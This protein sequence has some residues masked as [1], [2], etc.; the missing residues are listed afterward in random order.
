M[1]GARWADDYFWVMRSAFIINSACRQFFSQEVGFHS[2]YLRYASS[3]KLPDLSIPVSEI[4]FEGNIPTDKIHRS[5]VLASGPGGQFVNKTPTKCWIRFNVKEADWIPKRLKE[6]FMKKYGNQI[7]DAGEWSTYSMTTRAQDQNLENCLNTLPKKTSEYLKKELRRLMNVGSYIKSAFK[8][9]DRPNGFR[10]RISK[11]GKRKIERK[12]Q[13]K[14]FAK[15]KAVNNA[16][17]DLFLLC[18]R[19]GIWIH[20]ALDGTNR[21]FLS[22]VERCYGVRDCIWLCQTEVLGA[23]INGV[24]LLALCFTIFIE[25]ITRLFEPEPIK[26]P[27]NV[28]I[29]GVIGFIINLIGMIMFHAH[30]HG[31]THRVVENM[32]ARDTIEQ[33]EGRHLIGSHQDRAMCTLWLKILVGGDQLN[34][35]GVFLHVVSDA[36]GSVIVIATALVSW[37]VP[38]YE[39]LKLYM[40]PVLSI[41][42]VLLMICTTFP[43]V[44]ETALI[45]LQTTPKYVSIDGIVAIHEFHVWRLVG[46]RIIATIHIRFRSLK[47]YLLAAEQIRSIFHDN[48]IHSAT[49][50]PEFSEMEPSSG[51]VTECNFACLPT[52]CPLSESGV[53]C[54]AKTAVQKKSGPTT[55]VLDET[56]STG[57]EGGNND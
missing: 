30:S 36:I 49:I 15:A 57:Q 13:W 55:V 42:L 50:Q 12:G 45:L 26:E 7:N 43:L 33:G 8:K 38:D 18:G 23:L 46:E 14:Y 25:S 11:N 48:H 53:T 51:S 6:H 56:V 34:M 37:L 41:I 16:S 39:W 1:L 44:R 47:H 27:R 54:C 35:R 52:N 17:N 20:F 3:Q 2:Q 31:H 28:L 22:Y 21:R 19:T 32:Q 5:F 24:F 4:R 40:D 9:N 10:S 29:V